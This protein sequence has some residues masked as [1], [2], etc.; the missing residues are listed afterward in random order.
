MTKLVTKL[1]RPPH[2]PNLVRYIHEDVP[3]TVKALVAFARN[4]P[5]RTYVA[6]NGIVQHRLI[7]GID[8]RTALKAAAEHG[9][10]S[11]RSIN[12]E[13]VKAFF[14]YDEEHGVSGTPSFD[15]MVE[16]YRVSRT[17]SVPVKPLAVCSEKGRLKASFS[18]G[19]STLPLTR[20][21]WRL[22]MT[23]IED[24]VF[25]LTDFEDARGVFYAFPREK[26]T[27]ADSR[28]PFIVNRGDFELLTAS[29]LKEQL[30]VYLTALELA[31]AIIADEETAARKKPAAD[32]PDPNQPSFF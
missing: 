13:Y 7:L 6:G 1:E 25:T 9:H 32:G 3:S 24:A 17:V 10:A 27:D 4:R 28:K 26:K 31:K 11:S 20:Q 30:D 21:Q 14:D 5:S 23:M 29:E 15:Q 22:K 2:V 18:L 16:P 8:R 12:V 19:W